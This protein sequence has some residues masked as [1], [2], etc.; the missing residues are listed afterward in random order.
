MTDITVIA[1]QDHTPESLSTTCMPTALQ[2][3]FDFSRRVDWVILD[4]GWRIWA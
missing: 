2:L 1:D 4:A 3:L